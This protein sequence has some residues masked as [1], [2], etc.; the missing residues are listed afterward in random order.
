MSRDPGYNPFLV[1]PAMVGVGLAARQIEPDTL[2]RPAPGR[3]RQRLGDARHDRDAA[4]H[5]RDGIARFIPANLTRSKGRT[6][7]IMGAALLAVRAL[8][9][10]VEDDGAE[11]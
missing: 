2:S 3:D 10:F 7:I 4:R 1:G 9:E 6:L 5:A 8:D 11:H